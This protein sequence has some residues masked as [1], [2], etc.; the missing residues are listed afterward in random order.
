M[1]RI[2]L[3]DIESVKRI[4]IEKEATILKPLGHENIIKYFDSFIEKDYF[5]II[6]D[7]CEVQIYYILH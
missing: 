1:K 5:F 4:D 3:E 7:Y 2:D 6:T